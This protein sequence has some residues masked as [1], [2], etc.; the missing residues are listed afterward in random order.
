MQMKRVINKA[1]V[2]DV[3][4]NFFIKPSF[5]LIGISF[6]SIYREVSEGSHGGRTFKLANLKHEYITEHQSIQSIY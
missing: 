3:T 1:F 6:V 4:R 2:R 5:V